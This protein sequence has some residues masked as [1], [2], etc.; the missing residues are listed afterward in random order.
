VT[1][2]LFLGHI[3]GPQE[4]IKLPALRQ[5]LG[6]PLWVLS[7]DAVDLRVDY[8]ARRVQD[9]HGDFSLYDLLVA[10]RISDALH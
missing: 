10:L 9:F 6:C 3:E 5:E 4:G 1:D 2:F 8:R 7:L